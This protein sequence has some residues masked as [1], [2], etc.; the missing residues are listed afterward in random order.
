MLAKVVLVQT[1][2][3]TMILISS[4]L[5][6]VGALSSPTQGA[7]YSGT[8]AIS[9]NPPIAGEPETFTNTFRN[10]GSVVLQV[11][12][13]EIQTDWGSSFYASDV[14][15]I[16]NPGSSYAFATMRVPIP[17]SAT[18]PHTFS[19]WVWLEVPT[20]PGTWSAPAEYT[21]WGFSVNV[22]SAQ[23]SA[24]QT[25]YITGPTTIATTLPTQEFT[26]DQVNCYI[27]VQG[28]TQATLTSWEASLNQQS[29]SRFDW[30]AMLLPIAIILLIV[31]IGLVAWLVYLQKRRVQK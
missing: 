4:G 16:V 26:C 8:T 14:P 23:Q 2:L 27:V 3:T 29:Q 21:F 5:G 9:P 25:V 18:G 31:L 22:V 11:T 17:S 15:Q 7:E 24:T 20:G 28:V 10:V 12:N 19:M 13:F 1:L 30:G 6:G